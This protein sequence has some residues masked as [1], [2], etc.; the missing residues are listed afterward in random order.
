MGK[1]L[2][3]TL[4][5]LLVIAVLCIIGITVWVQGEAP[6]RKERLGGPGRAKALILYHPSRDAH[7]SDDLTMAL[8]HG[9]EASGFSV[10]R[11]T[12]TSHTPTRPRGFAVIAL[13]S[14]TFFW[15]PDWPTRDYLDRADLG[16]QNLVAILAG[17][18]NTRRAQMTLIRDI[19]DSGAHLL[20]V[21]ELWTSRPN[22]SGGT[23]GTNREQAMV[24]A[25][26]IA[27][28]TGQQVLERDPNRTPQGANPSTEPATGYG[29]NRF[30]DTP[31]ETRS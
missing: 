10:E 19:Q 15:A 23:S 12:M 18:G 1:W 26:Q 4:L 25:R 16:G 24:I 7:F 3:F 2:I 22:G 28:H 5:A 13:V 9:F 20:T 11:W 27:E 14:N 30:G 29:L 6:F 17:G 21:R 8:A 31:Y